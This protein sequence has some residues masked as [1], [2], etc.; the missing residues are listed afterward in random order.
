[1]RSRLFAKN[2][3]AAVLTISDG[4]SIGERTDESGD[5]AASML[6]ALDLGSI[7][8]GLVPDEREVIAK[9]LHDYVAKGA[10]LVVTT[11]GTGFGPRDVTPEATR[12]VIDREAPGLAELMRSA[13]VA[14]TPLAA[15]ARGIAGIS[16]RTLIVN[17]PGSPK[18]VKE[19]LDAILPVLP[20]ALKVL[21]GRTD[22]A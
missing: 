12:A 7:E 1:M 14:H 8:R 18:A 21:R 5:L 15:L 10:T 6:A 4:A 3:N 13:G 9:K 16:D 19:S 20:H 22:H 2:T 17:L 11:G